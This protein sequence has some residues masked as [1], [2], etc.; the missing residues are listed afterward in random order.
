MKRLSLEGFM[1]RAWYNGHTWL[2]ILRP[3]STLY[4]AVA[5]RRRHRY[6]SD[7]THS[8]QPPVPLVVVGNITLGGTGK[9][10]MTI[11]LINHFQCQ[12]L[13]V[14]VISRGYGATPPSLPWVIDP[15]SDSADQ[16]GDEPLLIA[17]RCGVP[18]VIDP[19]RARA[20]THL[21]AQ[22]QIDLIISDDGLQ[23]YRMGRTL[24]LV[25]IDAARGLGNARCLPEG[26]L[27]EPAQRLDSVDFIIRNGAEADQPEGFA[28]QLRPAALINLVTGARCD[29][30]AWPH[31]RE[32]NAVA[33]IG[34]PRRFF[35][36]L[37]GLAFK[38]KEYAFGDH[39]DYNAGSFSGLDAALPVIMTEKDAVKCAGFARPDWWYLAVD[40]ELSDAFGQALDARLDARPG[41]AP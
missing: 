10:P 4:R 22:H 24:E 20:G 9:T 37:R 11:W 39:A 8:W 16:V 36:T 27:R 12:G 34:N 38:P 3:L 35:D 15:L 31:G 30:D 5:M 29:T 33:G 18:V 1:L 19:D 21:L 17:R 6:L 23:H 2:K 26:P 28:M 13:R 25:M 14:G 32:V 40:A 7:P 41:A